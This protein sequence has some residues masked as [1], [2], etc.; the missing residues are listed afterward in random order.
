MHCSVSTFMLDVPFKRFIGWCIVSSWLD[1][2]CDLFFSEGRRKSLCSYRSLR[3]AFFNGCIV[4][5]P[6]YLRLRE[7]G[8]KGGMGF[9]C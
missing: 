4:T 8:W 9:D 5:M 7:S 3:K 1:A 2:P 6:N